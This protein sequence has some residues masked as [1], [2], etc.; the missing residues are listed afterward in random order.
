M[1]K[2]VF[3]DKDGV[4]NKDIGINPDPADA[5]LFEA[6]GDIISY[7]RVKGYKTFIITNQPVVARGMISEKDLTAQLDKF[8]E[9]LLFQN[10][11]ALIDKIYFCPH[12]PNANLL[13]YRVDCDCRKPKPGLIIRASTE[14]NI[15][16]SKSFMVGDRISDILA[17][18]IAGCKTILC[19]T[20]M[21]K[22]KMIETNINCDTDVE[23]D[24]IIRNI[25]E[26]RDII[27]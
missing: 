7:C 21:H 3:F 12:H 13:E 5:V 10:S 19:K 23:P 17:G 2:A 25:K 14:F 24:F 20:G 8:G 4:L 9:L 27:V 11:N 22:E 18:N 16:L 26:L 1:N 6:A 15:D